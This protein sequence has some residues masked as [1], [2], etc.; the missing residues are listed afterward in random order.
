MVTDRLLALSGAVFLLCC[1]GGVEPKA[2]GLSE[3]APRVAAVGQPSDVA[4]HAP[5]L[6][7]LAPGEGRLDLG[8]AA[9]VTSYLGSLH[10][11]VTDAD[12]HVV[13]GADE[14]VAAPAR[15][16]ARNLSLDLPAGEGYTVTL[17]AASA[18]AQPITCRAAVAG[19]RVTA[20]STARAQVFSW[21][22]DGVVGYVPAALDRDCHWLAD[23]SFVTRTSAA[24]GDLIDVSVAAHDLDGNQPAFSWS[25]ELAQGGAFQSPDAARTAFRCQAT[26]ENLPLTVKLSA[27][28]CEQQ[29]TQTVSCR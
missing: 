24:I 13:G 25:T 16:A 19:L 27:D 8:A 11:V 28:G 3:G 12:G 26:A 18:D 6:A 14:E 22:C 1:S 2:P 7:V 10:A 15:V 5:K 20:G 17:T 29:V 9:D 4:A 21:D 23:W